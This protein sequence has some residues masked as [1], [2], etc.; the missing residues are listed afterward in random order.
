[1]PARTSLISLLCLS[2][3]ACGGCGEKDPGDSPRADDSLAP[4]DSADDSGG[5]APSPLI[6]LAG[7][8]SEGD[9]GDTTAWSYV[10]YGRLLARGDVNGDGLVQVAV[11]STDD[12]ADDFIPSYFE[13][14]G[15]DDAYNVVVSSNRRAQEPET[16]DLVVA[17]DAVFL[18]GGDQGVYY[19]L[20]NA[21]RLEDA[22]LEVVAAGG[23][24][25]GTS[26][27]AMSQAGYALA[28]GTDLIS[29]DVLT[30]PCTDYLVDVT[31]G[32]SAVKDNF[33]STVP[34]VMIDTHFTER[35]RLGRLVGA[36]ALA[37]EDKGLSTLLGIGIEA[38]TGV[39][40]DDGQAEV[41]G[42]GA[43][44]LVRPSAA[45]VL[46]RTCETP[47]LWTD[48][49]LD[50]LTDGAT[51]TLRDGQVSEITPPPDADTATSIASGAA[52]S[53]GWSVSGDNPRQEE[54]FPAVISRTPN[55]YS[56]RPGV[57]SPILN[58]ALGVLDAQNA[59]TR[60]IAQEAMFRTLVDYT[61]YTG[62]IVG[63]TSLITNDESNPDQLSFAG[64][65]DAPYPEMATLVV[66][67]GSATWTSV[68][69]YTSAYDN[70]SDTLHAGGVLGLRLHVL[71]DTAGRGVGYDPVQHVVTGP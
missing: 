3:P 15:A 46:D 55:D 42:V 52:N 5:T 51:F 20:W 36:M 19:D 31:D 60:G 37:M 45:S 21:T 35:G 71:G 34:G 41:I 43:V 53:A 69:P 24:V 48:L 40:L 67:S 9:L 6:V 38:Q 44:H 30:D 14:L 23:A 70:G 39:V 26:A 17:A 50:V 56:T 8:G 47:L 11:V 13:A 18:K 49:D 25:G 4:D 66:D 10:L 65:P 54:R 1:M 33:L 61:G 29:A 32:T 58:D 59:D 27:G 7:G 63:D 16:Y 68:S 64:I 57:G 2:L 62:F 28:G 12:T 22:I